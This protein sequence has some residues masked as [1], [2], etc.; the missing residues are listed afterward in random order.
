MLRIYLNN[1]NEICEYCRKQTGEEMVFLQVSGRTWRERQDIQ[2]H[3]RCLTKKIEKLRSE[4]E[5]ENESFQAR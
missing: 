4:K 5:A 2:V 3:T 1:T